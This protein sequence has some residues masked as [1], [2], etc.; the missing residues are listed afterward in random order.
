MAVAIDR[1]SAAD[2]WPR[3]DLSTPP[4]PSGPRPGDIDCEPHTHEARIIPRETSDAC[5][6]LAVV[7]PARGIRIHRAPQRQHPISAESH[8]APTASSGQRP[9]SIW[10]NTSPSTASMRRN[11]P[12]PPPKALGSPESLTAPVTSPIAPP[13]PPPARPCR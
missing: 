13:P 3:P 7:K 4:Q 11:P 12:P 1:R 2:C 5:S 8:E 9:P 6:I 10:L